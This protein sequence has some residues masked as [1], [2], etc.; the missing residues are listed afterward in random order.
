M[1]ARDPLGSADTR[2][3]CC[4]HQGLYEEAEADGREADAEVAR[5]LD[6]LVGAMGAIQ[7]A[8]NYHQEAVVF[9]GLVKA[10]DA[11]IHALGFDGLATGGVVD[12]DKAPRFSERY[13]S[14]HNDG[15]RD[16]D[17]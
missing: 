3:A 11:A 13:G 12:A 4:D 17:G 14:L 5:L 16:T 15:Q 7:H 10:R 1:T 9:A 8:L 6:A 2:V